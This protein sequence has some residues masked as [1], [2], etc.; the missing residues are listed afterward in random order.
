MPVDVIPEKGRDVQCSSCGHTWF[1]A[2]PRLAPEPVA[3]AQEAAAAPQV[4]RPAPP[5]PAPAGPAA[6]EAAQALSAGPEADG[7]EDPGGTAQGDF[8]PPRRELDPSVAEVLR[9]EAAY[10]SRRRAQERGGIETQPELGLGG[11]HAGGESRRERETHPQEAPARDAAATGARPQH[12]PEAE[13]TLARSRREVFPDVDEVTQSLRPAPGTRRGSDTGHRAVDSAERH[14]APRRT[15]ERG[16]G[17]MRGF[18]LV[19]V[20]AAVALAIYGSAPQ[21]AESVPEARPWLEAYV[22]WVNEGR[23]WLDAKSTDLLQALDEM[24]SEFTQET[25]GETTGTE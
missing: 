3:A 2:H 1:Q 5:S 7:E 25:T 24:S 22:G 12:D 9:E 21:I 23:I 19:I 10:E 4:H 18:A 6:G 11:S 17:F 13:A 20:L 14:K 8:A 15:A 16:S